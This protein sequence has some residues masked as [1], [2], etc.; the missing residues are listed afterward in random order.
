MEDYIDALYEGL[1]GTDPYFTAY[2]DEQN[3]RES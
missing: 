1:Y 3:K 2:I